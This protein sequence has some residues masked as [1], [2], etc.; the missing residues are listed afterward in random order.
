VRITKWTIHVTR[1]HERFK[2]VP[3]AARGIIDSVCRVDPTVGVKEHGETAPHF[4]PDR[5]LVKT[6]L[7]S[8][9]AINVFPLEA[10]IAIPLCRR[11]PWRSAAAAKQPSVCVALYNG[12]LE[13]WIETTFQI[14]S[15]LIG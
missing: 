4:G 3:H 10:K 5:I 13:Q 1:R 2:A 7:D 8:L 14:V 6:E 9:C 11:T 15:I 12:L